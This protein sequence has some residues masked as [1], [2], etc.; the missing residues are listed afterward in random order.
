MEQVVQVH[1]NEGIANHIDPEP[2]TGVREDVGEAS[3]GEHTGQPL[4]HESFCPGCRRCPLGG[5]QHRGVR[6]REH[7]DDLAGSENLAC[8]H[9]P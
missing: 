8:V 1:C 3:A 2:C 5:R 7:P 9:A 6:H 4:S